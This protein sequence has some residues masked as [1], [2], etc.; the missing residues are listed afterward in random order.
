MDMINLKEAIRNVPDFP[1]PGIVFR[2]ITTILKDQSGLA[3]CVDQL[4]DPYTDRGIEM[5]VG[6]GSL[7]GETSW[8][9]ETTNETIN[10]KLMR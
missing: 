9:A 8:Q 3:A 6:V 2:D 10:R 7:V 1:K 5:V 4:A